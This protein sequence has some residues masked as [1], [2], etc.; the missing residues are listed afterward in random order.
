[1]R[2]F[3]KK[4]TLF[5]F[6]LS[7]I[8]VILFGFMV[9][10]G[11]YYVL[12]VWHQPSLKPFEAGPVTTPP[13][14]LLLNLD[15]PEDNTLSFVSSILISGKTSPT[16][17]I[18]VMSDSQDKVIKSNQDGSFSS[19]IRLNEGENKITVVVFDMLGESRTSER[20][21]FYSKEKI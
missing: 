8:I 5:Q 4:L 21:V 3:F 6:F 12:N 15:Q 9:I 16:K 20:T 13:K 17:E 19:E 11:I 2:F 7:Q 1:M 18:L 14:S 10:G